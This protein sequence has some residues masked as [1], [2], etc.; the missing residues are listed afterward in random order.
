[1]FSLFRK[2]PVEHLKKEYARKLEAARDKQRAGD[3]VGYAAMAAE[4]D[5]VL[6]KL[7]A[8]ERTQTES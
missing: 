3:I 8:E 4:A 2:D 6:K 5:I 7:E 1:V